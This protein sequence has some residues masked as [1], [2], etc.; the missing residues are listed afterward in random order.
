MAQTKSLDLESGSNQYAYVADN[1]SL[2]IM[3]DITIEA[4][5]NLESYPS[6]N[7]YS[8]IASKWDTSSQRSYQFSIFN[9]NG[10]S[11]E[12]VFYFSTDGSFQADNRKVVTI[13]SSL[14]GRWIHIAVSIDVSA[15]EFKFYI[16]GRLLST[17]TG[18][19]TSIYNGTAPFAIGTYL[20]SG[21]ASSFFDG[22]IK[23]VRAWSD[24]RTQKEIIQF[25]GTTAVGE[26][27][28]VSEWRFEDDYTDSQGNNDLTAS[29]SPVFATDVPN[30]LWMKGT[31]NWTK[32]QTLTIDNTKVSGSADLDFFPVLIKDSNLLDSTYSNLESDG[33][34]LRITTDE[35]GLNEAPI[36]LVAINTGSKTCE[37][38]VLVPTLDYDNDT[39][40]YVWGKYASALAYAA[41]DIMGAQGV[42][43]TEIKTVQ[44]LQANSNDST[45]N[46]NNGTETDISHVDDKI[47]KGADFNAT[48]SKISI[49]NTASIQNL[50]SGGGSIVA[51]I[52]PASDGEGDN[53][54]IAD[55]G[56]WTFIVTGEAASKVKLAFIQLTSGTL[57]Q[58]VTTNT[59]VNLN[60]PALVVLTYNSS[61]LTTDPIMYVNGSPVTVTEAST[62]TGSASSDS[63]SSLFIGN[64]TGSNRTFDGVIDNFMLIDEVLTADWITTMYNNQ[65]DPATFMAAESLLG[66]GGGAAPLYQFL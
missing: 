40:L 26:T 16:N 12:L 42:W 57:G 32:L 28:L 64:E 39:V 56:N 18:S 37:L 20:I 55:K 52:N 63:G 25:M 8:C 14:V 60:S 10:A 47:G 33:K 58:W 3:G 41:T 6:S 11:Y 35:E 45:A 1:A 54:K 59:E 31:D 65:N 5:I 36:E 53:G 50:F 43:K 13:P 2:S 7:A 21:S 48:T 44:H 61:N 15:S 62:P 22:K 46:A 17:Q 29:G 27:G 19:G 30:T 66:G 38:W 23:N 34:D 4:L 9:N 49:P 24:V 51:W